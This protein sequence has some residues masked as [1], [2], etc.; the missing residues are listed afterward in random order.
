M[1]SRTRAKAWPHVLPPH[2]G[3]L[4]AS[5]P[6]GC[7]QGAATALQRLGST[8]RCNR[9][10]APAASRVAPTS[11]PRFV[12]CF[13]ACWVY[14]PAPGSLQCRHHQTRPNIA[15][16]RRAAR[17]PSPQPTSGASASRSQAN[18][19]CTV[20]AAPSRMRTGVRSGSN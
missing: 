13:F 8:S 18:A 17:R 4:A 14:V 10:R 7:A 1:P 5:A 3:G 16:R 9:R 15:A 6:R 19:A 12:A 20:V 11:Q 2:A